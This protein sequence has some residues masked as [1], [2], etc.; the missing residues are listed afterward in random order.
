ME[1]KK[2][3]LFILIPFFVIVCYIL[4]D[5]AQTGIV[6]A[7]NTTVYATVTAQ[8]IS[9]GVGI[10]SISY[11]TMAINTGKTYPNVLVATNTGNVVEDI[12]IKGTSSAAWTL[13]TVNTPQDNYIHKFCTTDCG[14]VPGGYTALDIS[15]GGN[16]G[17]GVSVSSTKNFGLQITTPVTSSVYTE[18]SV[19]VIVMAAGT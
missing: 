1:N 6:Q 14:N 10:T 12:T 5:I 3:F 15:A 4:T 8:N 7:V 18:Q 11:N 13:N 19:N 9:V 17:V 16:I 2:V